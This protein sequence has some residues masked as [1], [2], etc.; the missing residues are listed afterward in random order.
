MW[1]VACLV[2]ALAPPTSAP[3]KTRAALV[4]VKVSATG[5]VRVAGKR[6]PIP[7]AQV[8]IVAD[9]TKH[10]TGSPLPPRHHLAPN[11][12][13]AWVRAATTDAEG[14][15]QID[16]VP[17][18]RVRVVVTMPGF[19]RLEQLEEVPSSKPMRLF[20]TP[21]PETAYRT[22][23]HAEQSREPESARVTSRLLTP[24]EIATL[25]GTQGDP[26]RALQNF[27]GV[28][29]TPGGLGLLVLRG[30]SP[31]Q[32]RVFYGEHAIPRAFHALAVASVLP[33]D[34]MDSIDFMPSNGPSRYGETTGGVVAIVPRRPSH[35]GYHG[36]GEIDLA[37][38]GAFVRGPA[39]KGAFYG[40]VNRG[41]VDGVLRVAERVSQIGQ[42]LPR[43][44]DYHAV[45]ARPLR[46]GAAIEARVL[47]AGDR[48]QARF[49]DPGT[50]RHDTAFEIG[51]QFHRADFVYTK[52]QGA[53]RFLLT[54]SFRTEINH[55]EQGESRQDRSDYVTSWRIEG[56]RRLSKRAEFLIGADTE[57]RPFRTSIEGAVAPTLFGDMAVPDRDTKGVQSVSGVYGHADL[58]FGPVA[59]WPGIRIN[60]F[61]LE[62]DAEVAF[63]P[64]FSGQWQINER[65]RWRFGVGLY[66]QSDVQQRVSEDLFLGRIT[67]GLAGQIALPAAIQ[68]LEP[69]AG[70]DPLLDDVRV[71]RAAQASS[72]LAY[73]PVP[74]WSFEAAV[75]GRM[76][77]NVDGLTEV[78]G[79]TGT[80]STATT[81]WTYDIAYG[82]ELIARRQPVRKLYGWLAYTLSRSEIR[83]FD[84]AGGS[85]RPRTAPFDQ[86]HILALVASY[87]LPKRWRIG[88]RFRLVSGSPFTDVV[89]VLVLPA[90]A[91]HLPIS[92]EANAGRFPLFHQLDLRVDKQ[93]V[94]KWIAVTAYVDVQ[95]VYNRKNVE[96]YLFS[97]TYRERNDE[98]GLP[99]FPSLGVRIDF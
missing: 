87:A 77:D 48:V 21:N 44:Y 83:F 91:Q 31:N 95:N 16:D 92:G 96:A 5:I 74:Q 85:A 66:S 32:S 52:R 70:F 36:Y 89:G 62:D 23:V 8:F 29:R 67:S 71:A 15:F 54:P 65:W 14:R 2:A 30:A 64:R 69:A 46:H 53:W 56:Q 1:L 94:R 20:V 81:P 98:F 11:E 49:F 7:E 33:A 43:Y 19:T 72:G 9:D 79:P 10:K 75:Y 27:P 24:A 42:T 78:F 17:K 59:L 34:A 73:D 68:T 26:L 60:A 35:D 25:P 45:Y 40:G 51:T 47:G 18:G 88:G 86:R 76:R 22:V 4:N 80:A 37:G 84:P 61:T 38:A 57:V 97:S 90:S 6:D 63:D 12:E 99:I 41:W 93:W 3:A 55:I 50:G 28:A 39:G 82:L 58:R 13:P